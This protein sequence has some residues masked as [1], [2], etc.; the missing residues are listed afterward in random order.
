MARKKPADGE[1]L[2]V[3]HLII[4]GDVWTIRPLVEEFGNGFTAFLPAEREIMFGT[5]PDWDS[6]AAMFAKAFAI[7]MK[8]AGLMKYANNP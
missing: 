7:S 2:P 4:N 3:A 8:D 1:R 5:N 6:F